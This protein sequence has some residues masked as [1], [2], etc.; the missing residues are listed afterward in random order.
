MLLLIPK[1]YDIT[2]FVA[3]KVKL[4]AIEVKGRKFY[5]PSIFIFFPFF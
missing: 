2:D 1:G 4:A 5:F 3:K